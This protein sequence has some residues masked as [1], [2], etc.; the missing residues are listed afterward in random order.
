MPAPKSWQQVM[1]GPWML[2][3]P[4]TIFPLHILSSCLPRLGSKGLFISLLVIIVCHS[5]TLHSLL[6]RHLKREGKRCGNGQKSVNEKREQYSSKDVAIGSVCMCSGDVCLS[7]SILHLAHDWNWIHLEGREVLNL[8]DN[9]FHIVKNHKQTV[10]VGKGFNSAVLWEDRGS[11]KLTV[12]LTQ[13]DKQTSLPL[14]CEHYCKLA[15]SLYYTAFYSG[16]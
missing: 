16:A 6:C 13:S 5:V 1:R 10:H 4:S 11:R 15:V 12:F 3:M 2:V 8:T 14:C 9:S 7:V